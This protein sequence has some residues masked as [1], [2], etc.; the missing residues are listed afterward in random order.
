M[1]YLALKNK[2]FWGLCAVAAIAAVLSFYSPSG[3]FTATPKFW[4]DE[5]IPFEISRTFL[6]LGKLDVV[7]APNEVDG[8]PYL[9]HATGFP[10]TIPLAGFMRLFGVGV[11]QARFFMVL[12]ILAAL[13]A[14]YTVLKSFFGS[15]VALWGTLLVSTFAPFYANGRTTTGEIPGFLFLLVGLWLLYKRERYTLSGMFFALAAVTKPSV[16]LLVLP[17]VALEFIVSERARNILPRAL[18]F[19]LGAVTV[20]LFWVWIILPSPFSFE[21]WRAMIDLY[22]HPFNEPSLISRFLVAIPEMLTHTT[23]LYVIALAAGLLF[24][25]RKG[26]FTSHQSRLALFVFLYT[27]AAAVY[28]LRS[29]G[30]LRYLLISELLMLSLLYPALSGIFK[31]RTWIAIVAV[32]SLAALHLI[33][34]FL[35]SDIQSGTTSIDAARFINDELLAKDPAATIGVIHMPTVAPLLP[36]G[37]KYQIATIGG[38]E[39]YGAHPLSLPPKKLPTYVIG[40]NGEYRQTLEQFYTP[41]VETPGGYVVYKKIP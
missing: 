33:N 31:K 14:L 28:F 22:Q 38:R 3:H 18:R 26:V 32:V 36:P 9:T 35:F 11:A 1:A 20:F 2:Y 6:E 40:F 13:V 24:A 4:R 8:R 34:F 41:F 15:D 10:L 29:P 27:A 17:A 37:R 21:S 30:W 25:Y 5:A 23:I 12:W 19:A 7:V 16:F 39:T